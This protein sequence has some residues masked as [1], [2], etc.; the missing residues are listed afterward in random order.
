MNV[1]ATHGAARYAVS[2]LALAALAVSAIVMGSAPRREST[3][4]PEWKPVAG[5][6]SRL[7]LRDV[8]VVG[9]A[10]AD[11]VRQAITATVGHCRSATRVTSFGFARDGRIERLAWNDGDDAK[12]ALCA[13]RHLPRRLPVTDELSLMVS[14]DIVD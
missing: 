9:T 11:P 14:Y 7:V 13:I 12:A 8:H 1:A 3:V 2:A 6:A 5:D 4:Q 10:E